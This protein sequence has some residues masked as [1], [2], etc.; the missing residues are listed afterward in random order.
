MLA[1]FKTHRFHELKNFF[2]QKWMT[3]AGMAA[4]GLSLLLLCRFDHNGDQRL[5]Y[6]FFRLAGSGL[7]FLMIGYSVTMGYQGL[8]KSFLENRLVSFLGKISY[9]IY[10]LHP[11]I[12]KV[13]RDN[14]DENPVRA[15]FIGLHQ[16]VLSNTYVIDFTFLF[17]TTVFI[18]YLSF[19]FFE[20]RF[21]KIKTFFS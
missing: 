19:Q 5:I 20:K 16:P 2:R 9:G 17:L 14:T 12:E 13:Y 15:I 1:Y 4:A 3:V 11:F 21:L 6:T 8:V 7:G 18:S 10:L